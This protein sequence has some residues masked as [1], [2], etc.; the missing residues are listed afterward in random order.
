M[1]FNV[2]GRYMKK[3]DAREKMKE[4]IQD[5]GR[6]YLSINDAEMRHIIKK[7]DDPYKTGKWK[8]FAKCSTR[9]LLGTRSFGDLDQ[10][11]DEIFEWPVS[12]AYLD[13][14]NNR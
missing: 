9:G 3:Q 1:K 12:A 14:D 4:S 6:G 5:H 2:E 11:L 13:N 10:A 7:V 8:L